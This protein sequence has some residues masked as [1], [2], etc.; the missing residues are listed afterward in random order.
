M[1]IAQISTVRVHRSEPSAAGA[2]AACVASRAEAAAAEDVLDDVE[3]GYD[4]LWTGGSARRR[5]GGGHVR[6]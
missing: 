1:G 6:L 2:D 4:D 5:A 3:E